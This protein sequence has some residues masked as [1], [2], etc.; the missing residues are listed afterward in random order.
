ME[1]NI[2]DIRCSDELI[3]IL[4][5]TISSDQ[6]EVCKATMYLEEAAKSNIL[7]FMRLLAEVLMSPG[8]TAVARMAAGLF[9]KNQLTAKSDCLKESYRQRWLCFPPADRQYIRSNILS[10]LGTELMRP[11]TAAQCLAYIAVAEI[12]H[13]LWPDL[14]STL[15]HN[16]N[17]NSSTDLVKEATLEAIGYI[18]QEMEGHVLRQKVDYPDQILSMIVH[19]MRMNQND[20]VRQ[21]ACNAM[22]NSLEFTRKNFE[23]MNERNEIMKVVCEATQSKST[24][25]QVIGLQCLVKIMSLYY[26][27]MEEYMGPALFP[28]TLNAL[29]SDIDEV[30]LQGIEF[31]SNVCDEEVDLAIEANEFDG[32]GRPPLNTSRFYAKGALNHVLPVLLPILTRQEEGDGDDDWNPCKAT[33]VCLSLFAHCCEDDIVDAVLPFI[34]ENIRSPDW[35]FRDAAVMAFGSIIDGPDTDKLRPLVENAMPVLLQLLSDSNVVVKDTTAWAI[36]RICELLPSVA[37]AT[38]HLQVLLEVMIANLFAEP[39]VA[40]NICW[41]L[42]SLNEAAY[43]DCESKDVPETY[44]L[45]RYYEGILHKLIEVTDRVDGGEHGLRGAAYEAIME[46]VRNS[47]DDCYPTVQQTTIVILNRLQASIG[48]ESGSSTLGDRQEILN[49]QALLCASL[50]IILRK[51]KKD[52]LRQIADATM[53]ALL[54]MFSSTVNLPFNTE[55]PKVSGSI[56]EDALL[57]VSVIVEGLGEDFLKYMDLFKPFLM[58]ALTNVAEV[59]VV[60]SGLGAVGDIFRYLSNKASPYADDLMQALLRILGDPNAN[61]DLKPPIFSVFGDVAL[62]MGT[63]F[64]KYLDL[65]ISATHQASV[66]KFEGSDFDVTDYENELRQACCE[67]YAG[68]VQGYKGNES[69]GNRTPGENPLARL[70]PHLQHIIDFIF[71]VGADDEASDGC[72]HAAVGLLGDLTVAFGIELPILDK[73]E[74]V[75]DLLARGKKSK[76]TRTRQMTAWTTKEI[77]KLKAALSQA[78]AQHQQA[79]QK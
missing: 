59:S 43:D 65:V 46:L 35:R 48:I 15:A 71:L 32:T 58:V 63:D 57:A 17:A 20:H 73:F 2:A 54:Q 3:P 62:A 51:L 11:S 69:N 8:N 38:N 77:K 66:M 41:A 14:I 27:Y 9:L 55:D 56:R 28:I 13:G 33:G 6:S 44:A 47:A 53:A 30:V 31:W 23:C 64:D 34:T 49:I 16:F 76:T 36:G 75:Q 22:L 21:A 25:I 50:Q 7:K 79:P 45:S 40:S 52:D 42:S 60:S 12:P 24:K 37:L 70:K 5:A 19:G 74:A 18:C 72:I 26:Q 4:S 39:R 10:S 78:I 68:I 29:K 67:A 1:M 61:R